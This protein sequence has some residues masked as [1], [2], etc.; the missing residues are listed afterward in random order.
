MEYLP[1][2]VIRR[3][4]RSARLGRR[5]KS[6][7]NLSNP[8]KEERYELVFV[9][10]IIHMAHENPYG[11]YEKYFKR[12]LDCILSVFALIV[13]SPLLLIVFVLIR[14][15]LGSPVIFRQRRIGLNDKEFIMYKFRSMTEARDKDGVFL[16][17]EQRMTRL[18]GFIR[19]TSM[20]E[21]PGLWNIIKGDMSIIGPRPLPARYL[22][23]YTNEQRRR[24]AVRP[25]LSSPSTIN[26]RNRQTWEQQFAGDLWYVDHVTFLLDAK[27]ILKTIL[28][29]LKRDGATA[30]DGGVRS[31][32]IGTA[33]IEELKTDREGNY[34]KRSECL[35]NAAGEHHQDMYARK[36]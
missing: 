36:A 20:D 3:S 1:R 22:E 19:K 12:P 31:E 14:I 15:R 5:R 10:G 11:P 9:R 2:A 30:T 29:V 35:R 8:L 17:D 32:F 6:I 28:A 4:S 23:R 18:G 34:M 7:P 27:S 21:L 13:L 25:G 24:H 16:P 33:S 26:G